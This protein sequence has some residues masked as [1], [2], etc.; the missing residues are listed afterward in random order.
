MAVAKPTL[1]LC[2]RNIMKQDRKE[3]TRRTKVSCMV[4]IIH[5]LTL[6]IDMPAGRFQ[7]SGQNPSQ[8]KAHHIKMCAS[9]LLRR[10][11]SLFHDLDK[12]WYSRVA[13]A[14]DRAKLQE[15]AAVSRASA[16]DAAGSSLL[17]DRLDKPDW[18]G[19]IDCCLGR[20]GGSAG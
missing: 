19:E 3:N 14:M 1:N 16:A 7:K 15:V 17:E 4:V 20:R 12:V 13:A 18:G 11:L 9:K 6:A 2:H 10:R 5:S 8:S